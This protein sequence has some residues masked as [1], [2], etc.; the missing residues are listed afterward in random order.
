MMIMKRFLGSLDRPATKQ[1]TKD[2][3]RVNPATRS[4]FFNE[5]TK[6]PIEGD[7]SGS[8]LPLYVS[9]KGYF[10]H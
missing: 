3:K 10:F 5:S 9:S 1:S 6:P 2:R 7:V 4:I 8:N